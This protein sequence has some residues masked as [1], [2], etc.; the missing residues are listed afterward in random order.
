MTTCE[1]PNRSTALAWIPPT[2]S[3]VA[4]TVFTRIFGWQSVLTEQAKKD[5]SSSP[6]LRRVLVT[7]RRCQGTQDSSSA[8]NYHG[9][10]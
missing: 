3:E 8:T 4:A 9:V 6:S 7:V 2:R 5:A 1:H 10:F